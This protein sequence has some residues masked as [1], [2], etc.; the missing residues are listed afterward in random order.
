MAD[1]ATTAPTTTVEI[2]VAEG[3]Y[4]PDEGAEQVD[5]VISSTY[6]LADSVEIYGGFAATETLR[7]Q[8]DWEAHVT[9]L[10]GDL[11]Q[12]DTTDA[13]GVVN[14]TSNIVGSNAYHVLTGSGVTSTARLDGFTITAGRADGNFTD[15]CGPACGGGIY[16]DGGSPAL[17]NGS[18]S[19][20]VSAYYGGG[21]Y[22][23][24]S[25]PTLTNVSF[26]GNRAGRDGGG[27]LNFHSSPTL[28]NVSF[29]GNEAGR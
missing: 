9:V 20:N 22:N 28:T 17:A 25:S 1:A 5:D 23:D 13:H 19:G 14:D 18:F 21:M 27:M 12:N 11:E 6:Q 7:S 10:S 16:N 3:V 24:D 2:W 26:S 4:Y 29:S 8:R 15:S